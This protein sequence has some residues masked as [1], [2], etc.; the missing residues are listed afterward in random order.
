MSL[1]GSPWRGL[2]TNGYLWFKSRSAQS[3]SLLGMVL[4]NNVGWSNETDND[5]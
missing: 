3:F 4:R 1:E 2:T 5:Y